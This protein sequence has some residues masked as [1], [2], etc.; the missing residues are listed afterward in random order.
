MRRSLYIINLI[1]V[2]ASA[3]GAVTIYF[4]LLGMIALAIL[5][6]ICAL[7]YWSQWKSLSPNSKFHLRLYTACLVILV[8]I[9]AGSILG[10]GVIDMENWLAVAGMVVSGLLAIYFTYIAFII[11]K[12]SN[13]KI[14]DFDSEI[15]DS[16]ML[17]EL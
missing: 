1:L 2:L 4:G 6:P 17:N 3:L 7:I 11:Y 13:S 12:D 15:L 8:L 14:P 10:T 16:E 9:G 5:Q